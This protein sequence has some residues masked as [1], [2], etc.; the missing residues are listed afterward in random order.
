MDTRA[1]AVPRRVGGHEEH[2]VE[3]PQAGR[4]RVNAK[5]FAHPDE[6][7]IEERRQRLLA[8]EREI[9]P[10]KC[11][12]LLH[13]ASPGPGSYAPRNQS[14]FVAEAGK[15]PPSAWGHDSLA[16]HQIW[17]S[18]GA[19]WPGHASMSMMQMVPP[20]PLVLLPSLP[21]ELGRPSPTRV[22]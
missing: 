20:A 13:Y 9:S 15:L 11:A 18:N 2:A 6:H 10:A 7:A 21:A 1:H 22:R 12:H 4:S 14:S 5:S 16:Q 8:R 17:P 3:Q 19:S